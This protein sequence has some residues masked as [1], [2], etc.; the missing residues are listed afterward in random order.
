[1][2]VNPRQLVLI[3]AVIDR[4]TGQASGPVGEEL[5]DGGDAGGDDGE[6]EPEG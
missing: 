1:M 5:L 4:G 2:T 6:E 3:E